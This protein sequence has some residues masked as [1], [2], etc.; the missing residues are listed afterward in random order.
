MSHVCCKLE[1]GRG[2]SHRWLWEYL[3][4][5]WSRQTGMSRRSIS[6]QVSNVETELEREGGAEAESRALATSKGK[7]PILL[8]NNAPEGHLGIL[9]ILV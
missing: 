1:S 8:S 3:I 2:W 6:K 7:G 4:V 5:G 9:Y